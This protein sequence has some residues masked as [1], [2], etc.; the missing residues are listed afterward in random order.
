MYNRKTCYSVKV[1]KKHPEKALKKSITKP[2]DMQKPGQ[3]VDKEE[4]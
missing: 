3:I 1:S 4:M 2:E